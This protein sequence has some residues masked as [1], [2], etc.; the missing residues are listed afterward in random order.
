MHKI[1]F[2][3]RLLVICNDWA[4]CSN[5][6]DAIMYKVMKIS[7]IDATVRL[8][9]DNKDMLELWLLTENPDAVMKEVASLFIPVNAAG[10]LVHNAQ[11]ELLLIFR[12]EHWDLPKGKREL[13]ETMAGAAMREVKEECGIEA[14]VQH[15]AL[16]YSYHV[17]KELD[18]LILKKTHWF[19]MRCSGHEPLVLQEAEGIKQAEWVAVAQLPEYFPRM[20]PSIADLLQRVIL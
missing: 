4:T 20:F 14:L 6:P 10:G 18:S 2:S 16:A 15:E 5:R 3:D 9:Q 1:F 12:H 19:S 11:G 17:Y 8:F 13:R 7:E